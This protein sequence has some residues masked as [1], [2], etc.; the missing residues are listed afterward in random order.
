MQVSPRLAA[1]Q[2]VL[3]ME[4]AHAGALM[5]LATFCLH[6]SPQPTGPTS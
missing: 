3:A 4:P 2:R 1:L 5:D 6:D